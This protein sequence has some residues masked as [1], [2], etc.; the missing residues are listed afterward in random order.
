MEADFAPAAI[1]DLDAAVEASRVGDAEELARL[2]RATREK[3]AQRRKIRPGTTAASNLGGTTQVQPAAAPQPAEPASP[4]SPAL[5]W[6]ERVRA[7][8]DEVNAQ[9]A[10]ESERAIAKYLREKEAAKEIDSEPAAVQDDA[11]NQVES[12]PLSRAKPSFATSLADLRKVHKDAQEAQM[13]NDDSANDL[14]VAAATPETAPTADG[15]SRAT[16]QASPQLAA[17]KKRK[18]RL[19]RIRAELAPSEEEAQPGA[20]GQELDSNWP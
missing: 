1:E 18:Q 17:D 10:V 13:S 14:H 16:P 4:P 8:L 2:A 6:D 5:S 3:E 20:S 7:S 12:A 9:A 15:P 11:V 19:A